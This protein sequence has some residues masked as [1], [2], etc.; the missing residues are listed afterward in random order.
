MGMSSLITFCTRNT[1]GTNTLSLRKTAICIIYF[2]YILLGLHFDSRVS[3]LYDEMEKALKQQRIGSRPWVLNMFMTEDCCKTQPTAE[4]VTHFP[5][6][7]GLLILWGMTLTSTVLPHLQ[8]FNPWI[9][10]IFLWVSIRPK[11]RG[12]I[13]DIDLYIHKKHSV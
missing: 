2:W 4:Q 3:V 11:L 5:N 9:F 10:C 13:S 12:F 8:V 7:S 1:G 6:V